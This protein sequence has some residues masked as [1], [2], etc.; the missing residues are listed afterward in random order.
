MKLEELNS[1]FQTLLSVL[2][3][4]MRANDGGMFCIEPFCISFLTE[5]WINYNI[6]IKQE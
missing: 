3:Y 6:Y 1:S 5:N 4:F 2:F